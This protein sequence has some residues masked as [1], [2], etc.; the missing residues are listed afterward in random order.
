VLP[1]AQAKDEELDKKQRAVLE[2]AIK[3]AVADAKAARKREKE[4]RRK[5]VSL[6]NPRAVAARPLY[7][8]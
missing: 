4:A 3:K 1:T 2:A 5:Q 7:C 6:L 8:L